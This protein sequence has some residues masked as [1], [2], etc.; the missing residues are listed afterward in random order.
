MVSSLHSHPLF[1]FLGGNRQRSDFLY[2]STKTGLPLL[3]RWD[4]SL[5]EGQ[6]LTLGD[7]P[8][9]PYAGAAA[10]HPSK[11]LVIF[12]KDK[13]GDINYE[14]YILDY[15]KNVLEKITGPIGRIFYTF[16]VSDDEW[17]VVGHDKET[18]YANSLFSRWN[19]EGS[20]HDKRTYPRRCIR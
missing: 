4:N 6:L 13:G 8:V 5:E 18:V 15:S 9:F 14:L 2:V 20:L 17:I 16:W 3:Y 7:E 1:Y 12:P 10:L 11:P 19:N